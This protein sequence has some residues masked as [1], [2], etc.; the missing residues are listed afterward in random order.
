MSKIDKS[1]P[2]EVTLHP[3]NAIDKLKEDFSKF[4]PKAL[5][6]YLEYTV[7]MFL[8]LCMPYLNSANICV[9]LLLVI[10]DL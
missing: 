7:S 10:T 5:P 1:E 3:K 2:E 6:P 9:V 8:N 4:L